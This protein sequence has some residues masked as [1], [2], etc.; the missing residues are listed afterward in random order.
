MTIGHTS[1]LVSGLVFDLTSGFAF[2]MTS[3]WIS[4]LTSGFF[5]RCLGASLLP[6]KAP[7]LDCIFEL[8]VGEDFLG[9]GRRS[10]DHFPDADHLFLWR[11]HR[12]LQLSRLLL[13]D[14]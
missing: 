14:K 7:I 1:G 10:P 6:E 2:G 8:V 9:G 13:T 5:S 11:I 4:D 3:G 12:D